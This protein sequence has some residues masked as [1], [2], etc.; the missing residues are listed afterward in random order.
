[1]LWD[2]EGAPD[3]GHCLN[4]NV[5]TNNGIALA[6]EFLRPILEE[7]SRSDSSR[8]THHCTAYI[9][10]LDLVLPAIAVQ[11]IW[12]VRIP[13]RRKLAICGLLSTGIL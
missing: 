5:M 1:M 7:I 12:H 8:F 4:P 2:P 6:G 9:V 3:D 13:T 10:V 11:M